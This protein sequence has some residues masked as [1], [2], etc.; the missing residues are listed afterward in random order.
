MEHAA[1]G[2]GFY[3]YD[4]F[5]RQD[6]EQW[7]FYIKGA[8]FQGELSGARPAG[9]A[10]WEGRMLGYQGGLAPGEE[11]FVEGDARVSVSLDR[12]RVDIDFSNVQSMDR[13]RSLTR[14]GFDDIPLASDGT[15]D[16]FD[17]GPV[18]GAFLGPSHE[19]VAG[20]FHKNTIHMTGSFGASLA[21]AA[22]A[23][24]AS[25]GSNR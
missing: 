8:G 15:F 16:G 13:E 14:F 17:Q 25:D 6:G 9:L 24:G 22:P 23:Q 7:D 19:E 3:R 5:E 20:Q 1:F 11:P 4:D 10:T 18:E 21:N 2:V 12:H